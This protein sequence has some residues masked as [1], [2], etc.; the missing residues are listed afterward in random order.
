[1]PTAITINNASRARKLLS[2]IAFRISS[3]VH[4]TLKAIKDAIMQAKTIGIWGSSPQKRIAITIIMVMLK[5]GTNASQSLGL[6]I[7][8]TYPPILK[9]LDN[10]RYYDF[11]SPPFI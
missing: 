10:I 5:T 4:P 6:R 8:I 3:Q 7:F 9:K 1:M 11:I 2:N